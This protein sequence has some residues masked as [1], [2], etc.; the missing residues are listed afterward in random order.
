MSH[1]SL[2]FHCVFA[3]K[4]RRP[5]ITDEVQPKLWSYMG[6]IA[7]QR[8]ALVTR[9]RSVTTTAWTAAPKARL[10]IAR[11]AAKQVPGDERKILVPPGTADIE[12]DA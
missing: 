11:H 12:V 4:D 9:K 6:G 2:L 8:A 5:L 10:R 1:T 3:A 7:I